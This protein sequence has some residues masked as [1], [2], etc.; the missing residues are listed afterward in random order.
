MSIQITDAAINLRIT[1]TGLGTLLVPKEGITL[2]L[3]DI[4]EGVWIESEDGKTVKLN[5]NEV[6]IPST[7]SDEALMEAIA[8][9]L[10][11]GANNVTVTNVVST[12]VSNIVTTTLIPQRGGLTDGSGLISVASVS[13][14]VFTPNLSRNYLSFQNI[15][16]TNMYINFGDSATLDDDSYLVRPGLTHNFDS[17]FIPDTSVN[18]ICVSNN[19]KFVAKQS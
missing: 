4:D 16:E 14:E 7:N 13:Q 1:R 9:L 5:F 3:F 11:T 19:K 18:V 6:T 17:N 8:D 10:N 15:S 12:T 2:K